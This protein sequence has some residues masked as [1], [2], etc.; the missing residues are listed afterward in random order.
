MNYER[1]SPAGVL[2]PK[3]KADLAFTMH[4]LFWLF[5]FTHL[6]KRESWGEALSQFLVHL[7]D[8]GASH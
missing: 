7:F 6:S 3:D 1:F 2:A 8:F 5:P 4:I